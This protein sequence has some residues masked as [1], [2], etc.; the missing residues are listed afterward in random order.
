LT[1]IDKIEKMNIIASI[2]EPKKSD[3]D[4]LILKEESNA[5]LRI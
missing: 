3:V 4:N 1:F 5:G 2:K